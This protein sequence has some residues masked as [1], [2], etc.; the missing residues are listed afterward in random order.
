MALWRI[1]AACSL[2]DFNTIEDMLFLSSNGRDLMI[3]YST[4]RGKA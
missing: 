4:A 3:G 2:A 1:A